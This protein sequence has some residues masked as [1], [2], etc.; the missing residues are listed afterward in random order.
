MRKI[1]ILLGDDAERFIKQAEAAEKNTDRK[2]VSRDIKLVQDFL[3][4]QNL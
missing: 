1:P 3:K 2:D 4:R